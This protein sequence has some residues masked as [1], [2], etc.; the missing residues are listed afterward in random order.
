MWGLGWR[1][2]LLRASSREVVHK[3]WQ[4]GDTCSLQGWALCG[5]GLQHPKGRTLKARSRGRQAGWRGPRVGASQPFSS[6]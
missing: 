2:R 6:L 4:A 3:V 5:G 1:A